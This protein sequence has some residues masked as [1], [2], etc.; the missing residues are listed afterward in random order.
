MDML[1]TPQER[2]RFASWLEHEASTETGLAEQMDKLG[3]VFALVAQ[4]KGYEA[5][6]MRLI[7]R[8]L[9]AT[10]SDSIGA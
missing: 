6:A 4:Q 9:R 5:N 1:L 7:A 10:H 2:D 3:P 8:R